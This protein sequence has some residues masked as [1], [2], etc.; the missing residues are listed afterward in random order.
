MSYK[1]PR[2]QLALGG[3]LLF[4][5]A[6]CFLTAHDVPDTNSLMA[7][8]QKG[9]FVLGSAVLLFIKTGEGDGGKM[10]DVAA[11]AAAVAAALPSAAPAPSVDPGVPTAAPPGQTGFALPAL[12]RL[13]LV[14]VV[15]GLAL[16]FLGGCSLMPAS[17][18]K[19]EEGAAQTVVASSERTICRDIPIGTWMRLYGSSSDRVKGWQAICGN[20]VS[21]PLNDA[22]VAAILKVY[23][24]F[25]QAVETGAP[26]PAALPALK[27]STEIS[28]PAAAPA[29]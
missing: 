21:A 9:A 14:L 7:F 26:L 1:D 13:L 27:A 19:L 10:P 2:I 23:P 4:F 11:L 3:F 25:Q 28:T 15:A 6:W 17:W 16:P 24:G 20:P 18:N 5:I 22:T 12:P 8:V 29:K